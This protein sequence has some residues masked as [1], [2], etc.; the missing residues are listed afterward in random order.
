MPDWKRAVEDRLSSVRIDAA[1]RMEIVEELSQ[2]LQDRYDERRAG[3]A[4]DAAAR[5]AAL[6]ELDG[7]SDVAARR[8]AS[9]G[10][11][12]RRDEG[13]ARPPGT[14]IAG[15]SKTGER[16]LAGIPPLYCETTP[17]RSLPL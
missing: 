11:L 9:I 15:K 12:E 10:F 2:H 6:N 3:G 7:S 13:F 16:L 14:C 8:C 17:K 4:S 1:R 5:Q